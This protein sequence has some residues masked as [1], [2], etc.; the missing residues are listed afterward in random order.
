MSRITVLLF[1]IME[2]QGRTLLTSGLHRTVFETR[3]A[4]TRWLLPAGCASAA[5]A[6]RAVQIRHQ[7]TFQTQIIS[8]RTKGQYGKLWSLLLPIQMVRRHS[9]HFTGFIS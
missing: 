6:V 5:K 1:F 3:G 2:L 8:G 4:V 9:Y 7:F